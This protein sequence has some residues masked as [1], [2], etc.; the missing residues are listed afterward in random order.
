M[1]YKYTNGLMQVVGN[2]LALVMVE[3]TDAKRGGGYV[4]TLVSAYNLAQIP[5]YRKVGVSTEKF[6]EI[7][8]APC[9][10]VVNAQ[11]ALELFGIGE[12]NCNN[13][14]QP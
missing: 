4:A 6:E 2:R 11:R 13:E 7:F 5:G 8:S 12:S 10:S 1:G 9:D 3:F 14:A